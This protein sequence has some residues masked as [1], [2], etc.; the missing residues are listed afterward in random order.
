MRKFLPT[1]LGIAT[2]IWIVGGTIWFKRHFCDSIELPQIATVIAIKDGVKE[3]VQSTP[4]FF[5]LAETQPIFISES[6]PVLKKTA[7]YLNQNVDKALII[8]GLYSPKEKALKPKTDL[9]I[10]RAEAIKS[11]LKIGRASCRERVC[12]AV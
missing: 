11:V 6:I 1:I 7:D 3:N 2:L 4:F 9:G 8:K 5:A 12:Y 10:N